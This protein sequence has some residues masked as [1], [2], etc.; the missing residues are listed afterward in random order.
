MKKESV[1]I[2]KE[3]FS[4]GKSSVD[5]YRDLVLGRPGTWALIRYEFIVM[6]CMY[7]PGAL[8]Y[9]LRSKL[10]PRLLGRCGRNVNFGTGIVLRHPHKVFI[11]DNVVIDDHCVLDAKGRDNQGIFIGNHV[12]LGRNAILSCKNG[13][14]HLEDGVN[15]GFNCEVFSGSDVTLEENVLVAAYTYFIGGG[16][17][18]DRSDL[19]VGQ[20][21]RT[22][23]GIRVGAGAWIGA[24]VSVLDGVCIGKDSIIGAGAVINKSIE[25]GKIAAG[26]PARVLRNRA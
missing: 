8:G 17:D 6:L 22:S 18:S 5:K 21:G 19:P 2:Q 7:L 16:H 23:L 14:I 12:F 4:D 20:Q 24:G 3:M 10:Y 9:L 1:E 13:D 15:I 25:D 26:V 11:G